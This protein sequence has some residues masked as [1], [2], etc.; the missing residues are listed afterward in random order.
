MKKTSNEEDIGALCGDLSQDPICILS[1]VMKMRWKVGVSSVV[2]HSAG[3]ETELFRL[4]VTICEV[5]VALFWRSMW[6]TSVPKML[7]SSFLL[8]WLSL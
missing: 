2:A 6:G 7:E 3:P 1:E 5:L 4:R 8:M